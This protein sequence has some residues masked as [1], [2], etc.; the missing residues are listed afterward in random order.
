MNAR[1][2]S[3]RRE[4]LI[5]PWFLLGFLAA[6]L[7]IM[8]LFSVIVGLDQYSQHR[9]LLAALQAHGREVDAVINR[10]DPESG[11]GYIFVTFPEQPGGYDFAFIRT[12]SLYPSGWLESLSPGQPLRIRFV[13]AEPN[14]YAREAV[15]LDLYPQ[16]RRN[17]GIT[18][19]VWG[20]FGFFLLIAVVVPNFLFLGMI[21]LEELLASLIPVQLLK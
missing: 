15:P 20:L 16:I 3:T 13:A 11:Y 7:P 17:P 2:F 4:I 8:F 12:L 9:A 6:L 1:W 18:P 5:A 19:D 10:I 14:E 21:P